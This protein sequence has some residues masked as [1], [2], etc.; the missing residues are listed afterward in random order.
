MRIRKKSTSS[1]SSLS[2]KK[3]HEKGSA[4][5]GARISADMPLHEV[6]EVHPET[7]KVFVSYDMACLGDEEQH[8]MTMQSW[9]LDHGLTVSSFLEKLNKA[10]GARHRQGRKS[11]PH[12]GL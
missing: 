1:K 9:A 12:K 3:R 2:I 6:L 7:L 5:R 8:N 10:S 11:H 4:P